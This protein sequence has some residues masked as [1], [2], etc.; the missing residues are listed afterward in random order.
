MAINYRLLCLTA[1][2]KFDRDI[3]DKSVELGEQLKIKVPFSGTGPFEVGLTKNGREV[4]EDG[5]VKVSN[6]D[7]YAVILI[8]GT[9]LRCSFHRCL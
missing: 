5:R 9:S 1:P 7:D 2:P 4:K 3:G 8:R 6:F